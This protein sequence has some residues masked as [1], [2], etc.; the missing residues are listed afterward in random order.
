M[1]ALV[2]ES[3][4]RLLGEELGAWRRGM[5]MAGED[6]ALLTDSRRVGSDGG[7]RRPLI[8]SPSDP[9]GDEGP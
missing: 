4:W 1:M 5:S 9:R 8:A 3:N 2:S 7:V 6:G